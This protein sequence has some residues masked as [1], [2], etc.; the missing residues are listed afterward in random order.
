[1]NTGFVSKNRGKLARRASELGGSWR[2][3]PLK[4]GGSWRT[5]SLKIGGSWRGVFQ[6]GGSWRENRGKLA[7][8]F[9]FYRLEALIYKGLDKSKNLSPYSFLILKIILRLESPCGAHPKESHTFK[10]FRQTWDKSEVEENGLVLRQGISPA[11][12]TNGISSLFCRIWDASCRKRV[13][14]PSRNCS[15]SQK[16][17]Q[18]YPFLACLP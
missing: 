8:P 12:T 3:P 17:I 10:S 16:G 5:P 1:M 15:Q 11:L 18:P 2:T 9:K 7:R 14:S 6:I 13:V 4:I